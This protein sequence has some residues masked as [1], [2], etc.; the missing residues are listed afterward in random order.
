MLKPLSQYVGVV[1]SKA[2]NQN[3]SDKRALGYSTHSAVHIR[4][5]PLVHPAH[6]HERV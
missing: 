6:M 2:E 4:N 5:A 1:C 3:W